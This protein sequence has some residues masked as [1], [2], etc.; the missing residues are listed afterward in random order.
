MMTADNKGKI[1]LELAKEAEGEHGRA[2]EIIEIFRQHGV[3]G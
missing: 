1:A 3:E 2:F